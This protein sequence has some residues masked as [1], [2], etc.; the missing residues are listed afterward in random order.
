MEKVFA[1]LK[2]QFA[3][4]FYRHTSMTPEE[5]KQLVDDHFLFRGKDRM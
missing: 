5:T 4:T 1:T 2:G 3:G